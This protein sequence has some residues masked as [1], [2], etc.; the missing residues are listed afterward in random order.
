MSFAHVCPP[1]PP[2]VAAAAAAA[3]FRDL[4]FQYIKPFLKICCRH[5]YFVAICLVG[6]PNQT[7]IFT[8]VQSKCETW[9]CR[10]YTW[11]CILYDHICL[12]LNCAIHRSLWTVRNNPHLKW[13]GA[14][15]FQV[16]TADRSETFTSQTC[17]D[18]VSIVWLT[19][20]TMN[21]I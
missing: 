16:R 9:L 20:Q 7:G 21:T 18:K 5:M 8:M 4:C 10:F 12:W 11:N 2:A 14:E 6:T 15:P 19:G 13:D 1:P 17:D 3:G